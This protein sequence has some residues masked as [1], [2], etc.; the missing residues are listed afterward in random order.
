M[1]GFSCRRVY[2]AWSYPFTELEH[3]FRETDEYAMDDPEN[4]FIPVI[5]S[6]TSLLLIA[7]GFVLILVRQGRRCWS[8]F[9]PQ[10]PNLK[11]AV[12]YFEFLAL[13]T[14]HDRVPGLHRR[15]GRTFHQL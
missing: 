6:A 8:C 9:D 10:W 5:Y 2:R 11:A 14:R 13:C 1:N 12:A 15:N 7:F 4:P 3:R